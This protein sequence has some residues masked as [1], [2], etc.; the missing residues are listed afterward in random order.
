MNL[1][2]HPSACWSGLLKVLLAVIACWMGLAPVQGHVGSPNIFYD[3]TAGL[4][5]VRISIRPPDVIPGL[6]DISVRVLS[7][8]VRQVTALPMRWN[9]GRQGAPPPDIAR[10]VRGETNLFT[11]QLWF[12]VGGAQSVEVTV[13]GRNGRG[14][15]IVPVNAVATRTLGMPNTLGWIL[16]G[17]GTVLVL[18]L[19]SI[20]AAAVRE[21]GLTA[22]HLPDSRR[23]WAARGAF[24]SALVVM[25]LLL[26]G[27]SRWWQAEARHYRNNRLY[28]PGAVTVL[29]ATNRTGRLLRIVREESPREKT[30]PIVPDHGKLMHLFLVR[31]PDL[32]SFAHLHPVKTGAQTFEATLPDLPGGRYQVF[33]DVTFETGFSETLTNQI[34]LPA[35]TST[36]EP[37][38]LDPDDSWLVNEA[39]RAQKADGANTIEWLNVQTFR[40]DREVNLHFAFRDAAGQPVVPER[41]LG[42][43]GHL[44]VCRDDGT[45]FTHLHPNGSFSMA[46]QQ[47]FELRAAGKAPLKVAPAG[48][49]PLCRL[50]QMPSTALEAGDAVV[51]FPYA[52]PKPG[53]YQLWVQMKAGNRIT[54]A[55]FQASVEATQ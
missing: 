22:G 35:P 10:P 44:V 25:G 9:T 46:A 3:G 18:L 16:A 11:T 32:Q 17:L 14:S 36:G 5:P 53:R 41:F 6:V 12:M 40:Q 39:P 15:V 45:V 29:L 20:V 24:A 2:Q 7:P 54:T 38:E 43:G 50:P 4:Y 42:M 37:Q 52:F 23:R 19:A 31:F 21:S 27:G 26:A 55:A 47:L 33:A 28:Q 30:G 49:D 48:S 34:V 8:D 51:T 1:R 13:D